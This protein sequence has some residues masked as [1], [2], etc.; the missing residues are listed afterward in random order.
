VKNDKS[1]PLV[2]TYREAFK[3]HGDKSDKAL[4]F[5][6]E[7]FTRVY[8]EGFFEEGIIE[9]GAWPIVEDTYVRH[10]TRLDCTFVDYYAT[11]WQLGRIIKKE[12]IIKLIG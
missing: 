1:D 2:I 5:L 9:K 12:L 10:E 4:R 8:D 11:H 7:E 6:G 3:S